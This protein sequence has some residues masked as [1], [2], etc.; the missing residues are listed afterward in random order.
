MAKA[1]HKI[2]LAALS[3]L[4]SSP[5]WAGS[6]LVVNGDFESGAS[7][8]VPAGWTVFPGQLLPS[9]DIK[10]DTGADYVANAGGSGSAAAQAN[11]FA[12]FGA[13]NQ[14]NVSSL[15]ST[16]FTTVAGT[17]Y[18]LTF[19]FAQFGGALGTQQLFYAVTGAGAPAAL[20]SGAESQ[21]GGTNLDT[22]FQGHENF[23]TGTGGTA[24][25]LFSISG[26]PSANVDALLDNVVITAVPEITTWAMMVLGIGLVGATYRR[27]RRKISF[28]GSMLA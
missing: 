18:K 17:A 2:G 6:N 3:V 16:A 15:I 7:G 22:I 27:N 5:A 1:V 26:Q 20:V 19:D 9:T 21:A 11:K 4:I 23:F 13:G 25:V 28:N 10:T 24:S 8:G 14:A 12:T